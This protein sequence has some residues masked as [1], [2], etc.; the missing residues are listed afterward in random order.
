LAQ[1]TF[2]ASVD[3][4]CC[5]SRRPPPFGFFPLTASDRG[6]QRPAET[7]LRPMDN[8]FSVFPGPR[9]TSYLE[10]SFFSRRRLKYFF[11]PPLPSCGMNSGPLQVESFTPSV[12]EV[13]RPPPHRLFRFI[14]FFH[15]RC[16]Y[17]TLSPQIPVQA[18]SLVMGPGPS[19]LLPPCCVLIC[20]FCAEPNGDL[21]IFFFRHGL[22][23][24]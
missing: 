11:V 18:F 2:A 21:G 4:F 12:C 1:F 13:N 17:L 14:F 3:T 15:T 16:E 20:F 5:S 6:V 24:L 10:H 23:F 7:F 9:K 19:N 8:L 22:D